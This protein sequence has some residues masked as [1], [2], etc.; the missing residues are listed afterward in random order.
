MSFTL[1][2]SLQKGD[3]I[4]LIA[5]AR[6]LEETLV[7]ET[8]SLLALKGF[9]TSR[10]THLMA[11]HGQFAGTDN[12][13]AADLQAALDDASISAIFIMRGGYG[14]HKIM[15]GISL[16]GFK[17][18]PK[19]I[20]GFSDVTVLHGFLQNAG[21]ASL[22][23]A[24]PSTYSGATQEA[25]DSLFNTL[26]GK[27]PSWYITTDSR[28]IQGQAE[29]RLVG[30][31][32]SVLSSILG[33]DCFPVQ[34]GDILVLEDI[35][36]MIYHMDRLLLQLT[37]TGVLKKLSGIILGGFTDLRDNTKAFGF[38]S[39]NPYGMTAEE[40]ILSYA[41]PLGIPVMVGAPVGHIADNRAMIL[42]AQVKMKVGEKISELLY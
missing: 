19:W 1:P 10:G 15:D 34:E 38:S 32:L 33:T 37:R 14:T 12:E 39:D 40:I 5:T 3:A 30:G 28:S 41:K 20:V 6:W 36:E 8:E 27:L 26:E 25:M 22:H 13:R 7:L 17:K 29:G 9:K 11:R 35:D 4:R 18:S 2:P 16:D 21:I 42:G 31:N 23:A 24:M